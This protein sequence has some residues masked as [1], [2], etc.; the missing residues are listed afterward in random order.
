[1]ASLALKT[2]ALGLHLEQVQDFT[3]TPM[4]VS[5]TAWYTG[6]HPY[7]LEPVSSAHSPADKQRQRSYFNTP[8]KK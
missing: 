3:P 5:T 8:K 4:T 1:M 6:F 2:R 7:S